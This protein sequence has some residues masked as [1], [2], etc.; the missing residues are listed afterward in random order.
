MWAYTLFDGLVKCEGLVGASDEDHDLPGVHDGA[1]AHR[2]RLLGNLVNVAIE[3]PGV[4]DDGV[5]SQR[6]YS[7]TRH[8]RRSWLIEGDVTVRTDAAD[9][10]LDAAGLCDQLFVLV[11]LFLQV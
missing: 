3:K 6:L 8:Q 4:G 1:H 10:Q 9:E 7:C 11:A 5:L 2:Q